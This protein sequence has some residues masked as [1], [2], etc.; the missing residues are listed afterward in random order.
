MRVWIEAA[1]RDGTAAALEC[2]REAL[3]AGDGTARL[4]VPTATMARHLRNR[5]AREG[6][7]LR[8]G[9]TQTL[10][11]FLDEFAGDGRQARDATLYLIVEQAA[12]RVDRRE[13]GAVARLPGFCASLARTVAEFSSAGCDSA[14]LA[15]SLPDT[16]L[17][18]AF[19]DVYCETERELAR[20]GLLLRAARLERAAERIVREGAGGLRTIWLDGFHALPDP[21]LRLL[22]ALDRRAAVT[23]TAAAGEWTKE[24]EAR[25]AGFGIA[26]EP[27]GPAADSSYGPGWAPGALDPDPRLTPWALLR[28]DGLDGQAGAR[29]SLRPEADGDVGP[30]TWRSAPL[31]LFRAPSIERE[32]EEIARR[33]LEHAAAGRAFREIGIVARAADAY[34]PILRTMLARFGI[35]ARF[36]FDSKLERHP[37]VRFV[38][39]AV[40]AMLS[41][42]DHERTLAVVRLAPRFADSSAMDRFDFAVREQTPNAGLG[43]LQA[44]LVGPGG[45]PAW[46]GADRV[47]H[48]IERLAGIEEWRAFTLSPKDWTAQMRALRGL[49]RAVRPAEP[50]RHEQA[51]EWRSQ[52]AALDA[53]EDALEQAA[54]AL[55][56]GRRI[57]LEEFWSAAKSALRLKPLRLEDERR[58]V[59][60]VL[61]AHEARQW[62]LPVMFLCGMTEKQFPQFHRPDPFFPEDARRRL[63][64]AGIRVR[65]AE[66]FERE[67]RAL[68][69]T[70]L[71][72]AT[73]MAV[74]SYPEFDARGE[75]N[76]PSVFLEDLGVTTGGAELQVCAGPPAPAS[77]VRVTGGMPAADL[78]ACPA[79]PE[80]PG[81]VATRIGVDGRTS[82]CAPALLRALREKTVRVS[83]TGI[84]TYLKCPFHYFARHILRLAKRPARPEQRLDFMLQGDIVHRTV[85]GWVSRKPDIGLLFE[86]IF[87]RALDEYRIPPGYHVE[88]LRNAMLEDLREF[89]SDARWPYAAY[90]SGTEREFAFA[91][92]AETWVR[93]KIDR[94]DAAADGR[95]YVID[96]KYS[97]AQST[98]KKM[99]DPDLL[100]APL[101]AAAAEAVF[102]VRPAG[103]FYVG[104][105]GGVTYAG[106]SNEPVGEVKGDPVPEGWIESA[107]AKTL[108]AVQEIRAGRI[109]AAPTDAGE[110]GRCEFHDVCRRSGAAA[111]PALEMV[112]GA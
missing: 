79:Y 29:P 4:I 64:A 56:P 32:T 102:R 39:G 48:K 108:R 7:V 78:E 20:R 11:G 62:E 112:E 21:E 43:A 87:E 3:R 8:R 28:P 110:C 68:F 5:I 106:W 45:G 19:L 14:R 40:E 95:A 38:S 90:R 26:S 104:L 81:A 101:Y 31:S 96:Y 75:R 61:S 59:V 98:K 100:Q 42:W 16:P 13:F 25:L 18:A 91:L 77:G 10:S 6:F 80:V 105:K 73:E 17:A 1:A 24:I 33:I 69:D 41:G 71:S 54:E 83:P 76:M 111:L 50:A 63:N 49:F 86:N 65:T 15:R 103:M 58:N 107:Q 30:R 36:Y 82:I 55:E 2:V 22:A 88:R 67:E 9:A 60:H 23:I 37:A 66:E 44:L 97:A 57:S 84:E 34:V 92:D 35:P 12:R 94:L 47:Q 52:G 99:E 109:D 27:A 93:G 53:F 70:A 89:A 74:L 46:N 72:A 51:L 85:A